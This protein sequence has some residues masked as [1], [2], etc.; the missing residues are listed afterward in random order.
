MM[1]PTAHLAGRWETGRVTVS[2]TV[3]GEADELQRVY[4][5]GDYL[6]GWVGEPCVPG[7]IQKLL[8]DPEVP[9]G[10]LKENFTLKTLRLQENNKIVGLLE[11]YHGWPQ[12]DGIFIPYFFI[13]PAYQGKGLGQEVITD[14][15]AR[16]GDCGFITAAIGV[17]LKNWP[18]LR[19]WTKQGFDRIIKITGDR[20]HSETTFCIAGLEKTLY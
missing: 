20:E 14:F 10:G 6:A 8:T 15:L 12:M 2:D 1:Q 3:S 7:Y 18:A 13:H 16:A 19:F 4:I 11:I 17:H 9:P 5:A